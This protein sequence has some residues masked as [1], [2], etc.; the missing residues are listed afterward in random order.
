MLLIALR[1]SVVISVALVAVVI[2][3]AIGLS[4]IIPGVVVSDNTSTQK[5]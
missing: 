3:M 5:N 2:V 1:M 4:P